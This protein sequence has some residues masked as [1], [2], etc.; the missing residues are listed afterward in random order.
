MRG[1]STAPLTAATSRASRSR[2]SATGG[3]NRP[4]EALIRYGTAPTLMGW[5]AR[6]LG[7]EPVGLSPLCRRDIP[8]ADRVALGSATPCV[9]DRSRS[10]FGPDLRA[11]HDERPSPATPH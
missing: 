6:W 11:I 8:A 2:F 5:T 9:R 10:H 7:R 4:D 1:W 3:A